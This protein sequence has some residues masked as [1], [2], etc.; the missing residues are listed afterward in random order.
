MC[1][2]SPGSTSFTH[3]VCLPWSMIIQGQPLP[4]VSSFPHSMHASY[5][6]QNLYPLLPMA[7]PSSLL[8]LW[9]FEILILLE[10]NIYSLNILALD[11][12]GDVEVPL[13]LSPEQ[14]VLLFF[15]YPSA[16]SF[17]LSCHLLKALQPHSVP[18]VPL[19][20]CPLVS[21]VMQSYTVTP[22]CST[23]K[24]LLLIVFKNYP[25]SCNVLRLIKFWV[26]KKYEDWVSE[27]CQ[28]G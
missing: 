18:M 19:L 21:F 5:L 11:L 10:P 28:T 25:M 4:L 22:K 9:H 16:C 17:L 23:V 7:L 14:H 26:W 15:F 6:A 24:Q 12:L 20:L 13:T 3:T 8:F 1:V 27:S 2:F